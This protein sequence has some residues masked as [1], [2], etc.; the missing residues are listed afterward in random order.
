[1]KTEWLNACIPVERFLENYVD[2]PKFLGAC[3]QCPNYGKVGSCP[4]YDFD[5]PGYW[6]NYKTLHLTVA[7][8]FT[9]E[10]ERLREYSGEALNAQIEKRFRT[11]RREMDSRLENQ[12][13]QTP[14]SRMLSAGKCIQCA[15]CA[16]AHGLPCRF[17]EKIR[18]S[19]ESLGGDVC[20]LL[21]DLFQVEILWAANGHL[22]EYFVLVGGLLTE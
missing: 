6:R 21:R 1:M 22:P 10:E 17:P 9:E 7:Q 14:N 2:V 18:Y 15:D 8:A 19:V 12:E 11:M 13:R 4:P 20:A 16:C 5:V 3:S